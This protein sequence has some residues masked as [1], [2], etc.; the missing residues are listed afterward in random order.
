MGK[1]I[2]VHTSEVHRNLDAK[3]KI[4]GLEALDLLIALIFGAVM[5]LF[6]GGT[7]LEIPLVIGGPV[8]IIAVFYFGKKGKPEN[9]MAHLIRFYLEPGFFSAGMESKNNNKMRLKIYE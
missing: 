6:F 1:A 9:F 7:A 4:G 5:N 2:E 3:F 8:L